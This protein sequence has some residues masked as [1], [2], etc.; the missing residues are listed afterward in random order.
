LRPDNRC[1]DVGA[2]LESDILVVRRLGWR[3]DSTH[4]WRDIAGLSLMRADLRAYDYAPHM[5][6]ALS[7]VGD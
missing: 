2:E 4:Y 7:G 5:H 6:D 3:R 1:G